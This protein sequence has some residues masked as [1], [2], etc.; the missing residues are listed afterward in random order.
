MYK[1][2]STQKKTTNIRITF[3]TNGSSS[4]SNSVNKIKFNINN[5]K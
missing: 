3:K 5:N 4:N 2:N 1:N